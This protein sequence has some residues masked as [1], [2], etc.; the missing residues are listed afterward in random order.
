MWSWHLKKKMRALYSD[1]CLVVNIPGISGAEGLRR[2]SVFVELS[3][4]MTDKQLRSALEEWH[5]TRR[6][7]VVFQK[8]ALGDLGYSFL[9]NCRFGYKIYTCSPSR[10]FIGIPKGELLSQ[11]RA[12]DPQLIIY[13]A[14]GVIPEAII[15]MSTMVGRSMLVLPVSMLWLGLPAVYMKGRGSGSMAGLVRSAMSFLLGS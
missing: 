6:L 7:V 11:I 12:F 3:E 8:R 9:S 14:R 4:F 2:V 15:A 13:A 1:K 5:L 10:G